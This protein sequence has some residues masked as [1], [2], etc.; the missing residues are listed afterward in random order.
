MLI[1]KCLLNEDEELNNYYFFLE[2]RQ[3]ITLDFILRYT[4]DN[5]LITEHFRS[6]ILGKDDL[7]E[8]CTHC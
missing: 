1:V 4:V 6:H 8:E 5:S 7:Q 3:Q 2:F